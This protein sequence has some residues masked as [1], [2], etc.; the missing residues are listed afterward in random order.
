MRILGT[1][2]LVKRFTFVNHDTFNNYVVPYH[3]ES[4]ELM[5]LREGEKKTFL[6]QMYFMSSK[7]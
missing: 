4:R 5:H 7:L 3:Y 6:S 2:F 1:E